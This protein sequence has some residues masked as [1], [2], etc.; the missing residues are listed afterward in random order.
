M[1]ILRNRLPILPAA[2]VVLLL[3]AVSSY[4]QLSPGDLHRAHKDLEGIKNCTQC[5]ES[6]KK[7]SS[8]RCLDCHTI[9]KKEL[10]QKKGLHSNA[11]YR[12]CA[13]CHTEH[14]GRDFDLIYWK[15]G[16][17]QFDHALTGYVL[18]GK[19][20]KVTCRKCHKKEFIKNPAPLTKAGKHPDKTFLGLSR[21]CLTCH[22]DEHRG[23]LKEPCLSCHTMEGW[24]PVPKFDHSK[25]R[26]ALLGK[27]KTTDCVKCHLTLTDKNAGTDNK[28]LKLNGL[29]FK[30]CASCHKDVHA[31]KLGKNC[32][33]CH[34]PKS[35]E[36]TKQ[37]FD[38]NRTDFPL[39]GLHA[40]LQCK[41]CHLPGKP[42]K[43]SHYAFC[44]DCHND[45]HQ[46]AF[47]KRSQK[48]ACEECH[49]VEGF[50]P[51]L[52][53]TS[54][55]AKTDFPLKG[56][57]LAVPCFECHRQ[58]LAKRQKTKFVFHLQY[59]RC[60]SCH[61][62]PHGKTVE[63]YLTLVSKK[64]NANGCRHCHSIQGWSAVSFDHGQTDFPLQ[65]RHKNI[66]CLSCHHGKDANKADFKKIET[67][68]ASCHDDI[69]NGQFKRQKE[70]L[71]RCD[72][73]HTPTD[74]LAE[75]FDHNRDAV[76]ALSGAHQFVPCASCHQTVREEKRR[77]VRY[78]P[79]KTSCK[80]CHGNTPLKR[81]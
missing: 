37:K 29:A 34:S 21:D 20:K 1:D 8:E 10:E 22:S 26:F 27:H 67:T 9:L 78:K 46:G 6:G 36:K 53:T 7:L 74:W 39:K 58:N 14:Q 59:E 68:C 47:A 17:E 45:V 41:A 25:T 16:V 52:F 13:D 5:H 65:G 31:G 4:A 50:K 24:K 51:S 75:K 69:H 71:T 33:N 55:H 64:T 19:H 43:I 28:Y 40:R 35:W 11:A 56:A 2:F 62:N 3:L 79:L 63:K 15:N 72:R 77:F 49:T 44:S 38:H 60:V 32:T 66:T 18:D 42:L 57:H 80:S 12:Q 70:V 54:L 81:E 61:K 76:F 73:C 23:Q 30:T 48:G